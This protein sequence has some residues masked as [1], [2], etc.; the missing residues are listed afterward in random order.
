MKLGLR[1]YG[2]LVA[3]LV[4]TLYGC[5][6]DAPG[7]E[8]S[9]SNEDAG[10]GDEDD[11]GKMDGGSQD[12]GDDDTDERD[13]GADSAPD[14]PH[15]SGMSAPVCSAEDS[16]GC[17]DEVAGKAQ[18][19]FGAYWKDSWFIMGCPMKDADGHDCR[20]I[21]DC[22]NGDA[23]E[24]EDRGAVAN[25]TFPLGGE[26]GETYAVTFQFNAI[27]E[28][29]YY[30]EGSY[31]D[32]DME[33][34][35]PGG[36]EPSVDEAGLNHGSL[37]I[38]GKAVPTDYNVMRLRVLDGSR[39]EVGRYYMN[40][41]PQSSGAESHRTFLFSYQHTIDVPGQ[42]FVEYRFQDANCKAVDNCGAGTVD[43]HG[44]CDTG[45]SLPNEPDVTLPA[46]Y[47]DV[48]APSQPHLVPLAELNPQSGAAQPWHAQIGHLT[49][50]RIEQR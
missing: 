16:A 41:F 12:D 34:A 8:E 21:P 48:A 40:A 11:D 44:P 26:A 24:F 19:D 31:A 36:P 22:P 9:D 5:G 23:E 25:E 17:I 15:D 49:V 7:A 2:W 3:A 1:G 37:Y 47:T 33:A 4:S 27:A 38:G 32:P 46:M 39:N 43:D 35:T 14:D 6:D 30:Q 13:S 18:S 45:R 10:A 42:G 50:T 20:I 28:G 29:K